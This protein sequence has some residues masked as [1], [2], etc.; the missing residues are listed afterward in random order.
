MSIPYLIDFFCGKSMVKE[1]RSRSIL[2][3]FLLHDGSLYIAGELSSGYQQTTKNTFFLSCNSPIQNICHES[4][5][6]MQKCNE[7]CNY[8]MKNQNT[9]KPFVCQNF[10]CKKLVFID[11]QMFMITHDHKLYSTPTK[12]WSPFVEW[13]QIKE[14][15]FDIFEGKENGLLLILSSFYIQKPCSFSDL[16]IQ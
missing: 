14:N 15:V 11:K 10:R 7:W 16:S 13:K 12:K 2:S 9:P 3:L 5:F 8:S 6:I 1:I 4:P